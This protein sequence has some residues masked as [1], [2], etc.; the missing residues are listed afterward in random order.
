M[1]LEDF[2]YDL[3]Q[4]SIAQT[5]CEPRDAARLLVLSRNGGR[6]A[7]RHFRD[8]PEY[9]VPGDVLVLN[10]T[11]VIPARLYGM[12][13]R[14][15]TPHAGGRAGTNRANS[16][17]EDPGVKVEV[18][19]L[20]RLAGNIWETLVR[21][22]RRV[23]TGDVLSFGAGELTAKVANK[24][25]AGGRVLEFE[26]E[27]VFE[28]ILRRIG[29]MPLPPYITTPLKDRER[30]QTVYSRDEGSVAAPTAGLHFTP[31]LL[32]EIT[33]R[34]VKIVYLTLHVGLGT[35]RPVQ[36][37]EIEAH[38]MHAEFY[39]VS[40]EAAAAINAARKAGNR[41]FAVGTT[42]VR[43]L[44][45]VAS[46]TGEIMPGSGWTSIFI[47]P[48]YRFKAVDALITNFHLPKSTLL[49]LVSAFAGRETILAAYREAVTLGYRFF[50]FGDAMLIL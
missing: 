35:F 38:K 12:R 14:V 41:I 30:Y 2:D 36:V 49:M 31:R 7:H 17:T 50:S 27:G 24:T 22:G 43:T 37:E 11:R 21:P 46:G 32:E 25:E 15:A 13:R 19:L 10:D 42:A 20:K 44:E 18:L 5:P 1:R 6:V 3:P 4:S 8:L 16:G 28:E 47:Y 48:G 45:T 34:G 29:Q 23:R 40:S 33:S 26:H 39:T 9:L